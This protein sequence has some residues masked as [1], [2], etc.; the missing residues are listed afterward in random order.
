MLE[1]EMNNNLKVNV[2]VENLE[3]KI[4]N[5]IDQNMP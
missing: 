5:P 1:V 2:D 3:R 4:V